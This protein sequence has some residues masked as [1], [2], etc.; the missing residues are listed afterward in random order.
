MAR[1][2]S[3]YRAIVDKLGDETAR[4]LVKRENDRRKEVDTIGTSSSQFGIYTEMGGL[5]LLHTALRILSR[6]KPIAVRIP[7]ISAPRKKDYF[8]I[9]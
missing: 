9:I 2:P 4:I 6:Y 1:A 5:R 3:K 8:F 7:P